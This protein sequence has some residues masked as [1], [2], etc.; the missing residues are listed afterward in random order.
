MAWPVRA[1][2]VGEILT[3][4]NM[5]AAISDLL[6]NI[7]DLLDLAGPTTW[8]DGAFLFGGGATSDFKQSAVLADGEILVGDGVTIPVALALLTTS[9]GVVTHERGGL[10]FDASG[11]TTGGMIQGA[12]AGV[13]ELLP[14]GSNGQFLTITGGKATWAVGSLTQATQAALEAET[15]EN[16][17]APPD[18][19][20]HSPGVAKAY[21]T[22]ASD[23][24]LQSNS[25]NITSSA[26]DSTG[27]Y[28]VTWNVD[29]ANANYAVAIAIEDGTLAA[30]T[31]AMDTVPV[32]GSVA[33]ITKNSGTKVDFPTHVAAFGDQ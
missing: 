30:L 9:T 33:Y 8:V 11:V 23:G 12:S 15:N 31:A 13:L 17:Y 6:Q 32:E 10:E 21:C 2:A 28:T 24:T 14:I 26:K 27:D 20:K 4:A 19:I 16:T 7:D 18:L 29:F 1:W 22:V 3:S 5:I 25:Y